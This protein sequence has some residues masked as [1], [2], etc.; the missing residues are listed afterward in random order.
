MKPIKTY[1]PLFSG[2][3]N[4]L[5]EPDT[6]NFEN[7]N[8]C[9][10]DFNNSQYEIDVVKECIDFVV[11]NCEFVKSIKFESVVS[12][13]YYNYSNDSANI[14]VKL[15]R[16]GFKRY[17][18]ENRVAL[19]K[20]LKDR[21]TSCSGFISHYGNSFE[22]W[23]IETSN[24]KDLEGHY[25]GSLLDFYFNNEGIG[26]IDMYYFVMERIYI[27]NYCEITKLPFSELENNRKKEVLKELVE[28]NEIDLTF[29]YNEI[30]L[31][32]ANYKS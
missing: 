27:D 14:V 30:L 21:Y 5:F 2:F 26:V 1:L 16:V 31:N 23:L 12:P 17:L 13:K 20:Y 10:Y 4:T 22:E 9:T 28:S 15:N 25:L 3:Y 19:D 32:E 29:G 11:E 6:T 7:E 18:K 24:F 8:N